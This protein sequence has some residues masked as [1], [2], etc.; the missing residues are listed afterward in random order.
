MK[1]RIT[2]IILAATAAA[3]LAACGQ[4]TTVSNTDKIKIVTT[5]FPEYDWAREIVGDNNDKVDVTMLVNN[6]T[7]IHS[8]QPTAED[9]LKISDCDVLVYVGGESDSWVGEA[10]EQS[11]NKDMQIIKLLDVLGEDAKEEEHVEGM[12]SETAEE[13]ETEYDEHVWM[14]LKNAQTFCTAI[15]SA[16][17][18]SDTDHA[19]DYR[20]N[21]ETYSQKLS[22]LDSEYTIAVNESANKT[23]LFADR[24]PFRYLTDDYGIA[25]YAAFEGCSAETEA[26]FETIT[27]LAGK[28]DELGLKNVITTE[29]SDQKIAQTIIQNTKDKNQGILGLDSMQSVSLSDAENGTTYLGIAEKNLNVIKEALQ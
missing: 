13:D 1:K 12:E 7:D 20:K 11:T 6:G 10:A 5:S 25:Y 29:K 23:M 28:V 4:S 21:L 27:F 18:K 8:Y 16:I 22:E 15:E 24:F 2:A 14:S 19:E 3:G 9:I 26:S 17:E